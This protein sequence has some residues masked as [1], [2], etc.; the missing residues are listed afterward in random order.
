MKSASRTRPASL[1]E[2]GVVIT[3]AL[4]GRFGPIGD[5]GAGP[6]PLDGDTALAEALIGGYLISFASAQAG[7]HFS[8]TTLPEIAPVFF[9]LA[10]RTLEVIGG[11]DRLAAPLALERWL[12]GVH[13]RRVSPKGAGTSTAWI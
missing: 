4:W 1:R 5:P 7:Q 11:P 10:V 9:S 3:S 2:K 13:G 12:G 8:W 6:P